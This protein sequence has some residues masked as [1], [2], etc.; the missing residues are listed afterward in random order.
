[1]V[2]GVGGN[3][4]GAGGAVPE[5][6]GNAHGIGGARLAETLAPPDFRGTAADF[7]GRVLNFTRSRRTL[8]GRGRISRAAKITSPIHWQFLVFRLQVFEMV[9][10]R[11]AAQ[12]LNPSSVMA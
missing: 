11:L 5:I 7:A 12:G 6:G 10:S 8:R 2:S 1:M 3:L 4:A 9:G